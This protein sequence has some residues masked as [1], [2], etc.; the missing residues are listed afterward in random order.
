MT[1]V[2]DDVKESETSRFKHEKRDET[3]WGEIGKNRRNILD[4][5]RKTLMKYYE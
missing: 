2:N 4:D 3:F 1:V 5:T